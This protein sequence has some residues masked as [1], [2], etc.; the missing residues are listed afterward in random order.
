MYEFTKR[1]SETERSA[2][3]EW[4]KLWRVTRYEN[5]YSMSYNTPMRD[6]HRYVKIVFAL[7]LSIFLV[8]GLTG[9]VHVGMNVQANGQMAPCPFMGKGAVCNMSP[10]EHLAALQDAFTTTVENGRNVALFLVTLT[11]LLTLGFWK[12]FFTKRE[13]LASQ[14]MPPPPQ[15]Q[16]RIFD[17]LQEVFA[18][19]ILHSKAF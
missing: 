6:L 10:L 18:R 17:P 8:F 16:T 12:G 11:L 7:A 14:R 2:D 19:G 5:G 15:E 13:N 4:R 9:A 1:R 3:A